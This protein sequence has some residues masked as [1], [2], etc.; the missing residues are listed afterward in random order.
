MRPLFDQ[1]ASSEAPSVAGGR[2]KE[3]RPE[4]VAVGR[5]IRERRKALG[6]TQLELATK[7]GLTDISKHERG[8]LGTSAATLTA[9]AKELQVTERWLREGDKTTSVESE[10]VDSPGWLAVMQDGTVDRVR[11]RGVSAEQIEHVRRTPGWKNGGRPEDY[12]RALE[13]L[14]LSAIERA[15]LDESARARSRRSADLGDELP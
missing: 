13:A 3:K 9:L 15:E 4:D 1:P 8:E 11:Q 5:R 2:R 7:V 6:L 12:R 10:W 14:L